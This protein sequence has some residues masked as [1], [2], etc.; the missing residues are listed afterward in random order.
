MTEREK[1]E[2]FKEGYWTGRLDGL[3]NRYS[4][5]AAMWVRVTRPDTYPYH[6]SHGYVIGTRDA[7]LEGAGRA[8]SPVA[9]ASLGTPV[10]RQNEPGS[11]KH[12]PASR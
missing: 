5:Y 2:A 4:G 12:R 3:L 7:Q 9:M 11:R 8:I 10:R 1:N 6:Y